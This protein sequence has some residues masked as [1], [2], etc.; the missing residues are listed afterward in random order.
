M[1]LW[2]GEM[3]CIVTNMRSSNRV[4]N[5]KKVLLLRMS[6]N[7]L[8]VSESLKM[9]SM[10]AFPL[11]CILNLSTKQEWKFA[12]L[13]TGQLVYDFKVTHV[14]RAFPDGLNC[15]NNP[16]CRLWLH[17]WGLRQCL[18]AS[19]RPFEPVPH[20]Y[21]AK[22]LLNL[23]QAAIHP[24]RNPN[25]NCTADHLPVFALHQPH[26]WKLAGLVHLIPI[27]RKQFAV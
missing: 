1:F 11:P 12:R 20:E 16:Q 13:S 23:S 15:S 4:L 21:G 25:V 5:P 19:L 10:V 6:N 2:A 8:I 18:D 9:F 14:H 17:W 7:V 22:T 27:S 24:G 26:C 3:E